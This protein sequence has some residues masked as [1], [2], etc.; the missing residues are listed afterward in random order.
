MFYQVIVIYKDTE[1][2]ASIYVIG[3]T[4]S[5]CIYRP[6]TVHLLTREELSLVTEHLNRPSIKE[7]IKSIHVKTVKIEDYV[8]Y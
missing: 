8:I 5:G 1:E 4:V 6:D 3:K 7:S 2:E